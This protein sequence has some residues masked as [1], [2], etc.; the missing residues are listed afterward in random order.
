[1]VGLKGGAAVI[2]PPEPDRS[3]TESFDRIS[4][5]LEPGSYINR[6][7]DTSLS[8][9]K[10]TLATCTTDDS[11]KQ[12]FGVDENEDRGN[13]TGRWDFLLSLLGYAVGL[14]NVWRFP[15][16]CYRNGGGAFLIP[17]V[18]MMG[19]I[20]I[21]LFYME[22][23]LGQFC[24]SGPMTCWKFAPLFKGVGIAMVIVS[25]LTSLYYNMIL[26]WSFYYMFASFTSELPWQSCI[27]EWNTPNCSLKL[28]LVPCNE[29]TQ[30]PN[31]TCY[32]GEA[33]LGLWNYT[34]FKN[35]TGRVRVSP[36][37]EYWNNNALGMSDSFENF[38]S[39]KWQLVLP[40]ML[41]WLVCFLCLIKGIKTTGKVV[42]FTAIFPYVV[43]L[44][45]FFRGVT[46]EN[47]GLGIEYYIIPRWERLLDARVWKDAAVQIFFSMSVAGGGLITLSS[48]NRFHN[49]ILKDSI[50]VTV[51]DTLTC[52]FA[53]FVI[54]SYLGFM[55]GKLNVPVDQVAR[56]GA[57]LAFVVY[58]EAVTN[59]PA[60]PLWSILFFFM[61]ITLGLDSEFAMLETVLTGCMDQFP[62][63]RPWKTYVILAICCIFFILGL[64]L[65][66]NGGMYL[67]QLMDNYVGGWT[68]L[69]IGFTECMVIAY[70]Y[71]LDR[72]LQDI[73]IMIGYHNPIYWKVCWYAVSPL[74]IVFIFIFTF[75][76]YTPSTYGDYNY[77]AWAD[78]LGWIMA[79]CSVLAIPITMVYMVKKEDDFVELPKKLRVLVTP[80]RDWGPALFKHRKL[81]TYV[82]GWVLDPQAEKSPFTY[83][84]PGFRDKSMSDLRV[85]L[86]KYIYTAI[87]V[88]TNPSEL[89]FS[90]STGNVSQWSAP[91]QG[92]ISQISQAS[93][94]SFES[95]V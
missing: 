21:P 27:N 50:I 29:G 2:E 12:I 44:I 88:T 75:V 31:G 49:N 4:T 66:C 24:S 8:Q 41:A 71:G 15:Y 77:P 6:G 91:S 74:A 25:G 72:F 43:L 87:V 80:S 84:N 34:I 94:V 51:A 73:E 81:V 63:L 16:L 3:S 82:D 52:I 92:D 10:D 59:L 13:W 78:A 11:R 57:G 42:Y 33:F 23:S 37:E 5:S 39:P 83:T 26:G 79:I 64:P 53:G 47:A 1:M 95:N 61:L 62:K 70:A 22:A 19:I 69:I 17:F 55:A 85:S 32:Q 48:Y 65:T 20:G 7:Y 58:P 90:R 76:D 67:L 93:Q 38:G 68:L 14:G 46:L 86:S 54:F 35:T 45:L 30:Y 56:D 36:S 28:P 18:L 89:S 9:S 40:L 60:P